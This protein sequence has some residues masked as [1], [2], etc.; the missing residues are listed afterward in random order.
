MYWALT[1]AHRWG[2]RS[3]ACFLR[4]APAGACI[5]LAYISSWAPGSRRW[6]LSW[7]SF[8]APRSTCPTQPLC[9]FTP[10]FHPG[11]RFTCER[12]C[13]RLHVFTPAPLQ[14]LVVNLDFVVGGRACSHHCLVHRRFAICRCMGFSTMAIY[15]FNSTVPRLPGRC[16]IALFAERGVL[17][18]TFRSVV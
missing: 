6:D 5:S 11:A 13:S 7:F 3:G 1:V 15:T 8:G 4:C 18:T 14:R 17:G 2:T 12:L 10:L 9:L 16:G